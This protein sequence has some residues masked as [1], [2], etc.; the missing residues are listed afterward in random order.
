MRIIYRLELHQSHVRYF[1]VAILTFGR[2]CFDLTFMKRA[3]HQV[4]FYLLAVILKIYL[5]MQNTDLNVLERV[6]APTPKFFRVIRNVGLVLGAVGTTILTAGAALPVVVTSIAG[7]M[8]TV[9]AVA[10]AV[11]QTTVDWKAYERQQFR[12]L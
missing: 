4:E 7:Y 1:R 11:S 2:D 3:T 12:G 10:A 6:K 8:V 9:G 5:I